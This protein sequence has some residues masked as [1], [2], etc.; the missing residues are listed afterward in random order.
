[1]KFRASLFIVF[2]LLLGAV[3][4]MANSTVGQDRGTQQDEG[5]TFEY[6]QLVIQGDAILDAQNARV[7]WNE[8]DR[9]LT[10]NFISLSALNRLLSRQG[11]R[12]TLANLLNSIGNNGWELITVD[13]SERDITAWTFIREL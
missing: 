7:V 1:M 12:P 10:P 9:N 2:T 11:Q 8:G 3:I 13:R 6:A 4:V 5:P